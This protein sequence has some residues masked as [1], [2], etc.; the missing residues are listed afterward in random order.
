MIYQKDDDDLD[1]KNF[2]ALLSSQ[3][4]N[5]NGRETHREKEHVMKFAESKI[6][7]FSCG[8]PGHKKA[9]CRNLK[10]NSSPARRRRWCENC[11]YRKKGRRGSTGRTSG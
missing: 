11:Q 2:K 7:C 10:N 1:F 3:E 4:E 5:E 6:T 8:K 9:E